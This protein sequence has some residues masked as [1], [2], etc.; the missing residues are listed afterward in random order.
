MKT[1]FYFI[2]FLM[3]FIDAQ[4]QSI[5]KRDFSKM[6]SKFDITVVANSQNE[7]DE[8]IDLAIDEIDRIENLISSWK[9]TS[10]TSEIN[11]NAGIK[12][13][14]VD[15]ELFSLIQRN[16]AISRL[17]DG[18]FDIS[19]AAVDRIWNFDKKNHTWP[20]QQTLENSVRNVGFENIKINEETS[21]IFLSQKEMKIGFGAIGKGYAADKVK[22]LL[23]GKGVTGGIINASGDMSAW[24]TQPG[25][26][27]WKV[28]ITNPL[29]QTKNY[30]LF[31]LRDKAVVT[32]GNYEKFIKIDD[33]VYSHI[34][35]PRTG[36]PTKGTLSV[37]VFAPKAELADALATSISVMGADA[38]VYLINQLPDVECIIIT[39]G[40]NVINSKGIKINT[41]E[42]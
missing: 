12:F 13:I 10:Q 36:K 42:N 5:Y 25:G 14:K 24:G 16:I 3:A 23:Q 17:T 26:K 39:Q 34:I 22:A 11:K 1:S 7:A 20:D 18:A 28:A 30:G 9:S 21:Q 40:G 6:G 8:F 29:D 35:D 33:E 27:A 38:G 19:Y 2:I 41:Y 15:A 32:S 4:S 31:E 37:S